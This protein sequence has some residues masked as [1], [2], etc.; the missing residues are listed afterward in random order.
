MLPLRIT[1]ANLLQS[2]L[3][4]NTL[5]PPPPRPPWTYCKTADVSTGVRRIPHLLGRWA[6]NGCKKSHSS[7]TY[8][9]RNERIQSK[10]VRLYDRGLCGGCLGMLV[11]HRCH[12]ALGAVLEKVTHST[13]KKPRRLRSREGKQVNHA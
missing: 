3:K 12:H 13:P 8:F 11:H 6:L 9:C 4:K 10:P 5:R 2:L 7:W 1:H